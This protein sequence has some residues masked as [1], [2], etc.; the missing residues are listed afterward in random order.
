M[1][2]FRS[3]IIRLIK[4]T[5]SSPLPIL[6]KEIYFFEN[7][8]TNSGFSREALYQLLFFAAIKLVFKQLIKILDFPK[9]FALLMT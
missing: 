4:S 1:N 5:K 7:S 9:I 2:L 6:S 8:S 3:E